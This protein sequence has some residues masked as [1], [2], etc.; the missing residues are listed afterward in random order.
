MVNNQARWSPGQHQ[1][2]V[3]EDC[4][5]GKQTEREINHVTSSANSDLTFVHYI[6]HFKRFCTNLKIP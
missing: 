5:S 6:L 4:H 3:A 1:D 2:K